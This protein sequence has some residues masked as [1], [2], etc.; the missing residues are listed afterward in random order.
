MTRENLGGY[1]GKLVVDIVAGKYYFHNYRYGMEMYV[2]PADVREVLEYPSRKRWGSGRSYS[3]DLYEQ[4][5]NLIIEYLKRKVCKYKTITDVIKS[6][7]KYKRKYLMQFSM[8]ELQK[9]IDDTTK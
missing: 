7:S 4:D 1:D 3:N 6:K 2:S 9:Y 8:D 5:R